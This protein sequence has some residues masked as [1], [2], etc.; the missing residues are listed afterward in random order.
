M[1][2]STKTIAVEITAVTLFA[3]VCTAAILVLTAK[4]ETRGP[5]GPVPV[6]SVSNHK[7]AQ[8]TPLEPV[9]VPVAEDIKGPAVER[10]RERKPLIDRVEPE[11]QPL[12][13]RI[14][15]WLDG[16]RDEEKIENRKQKRREWWQN[17]PRPFVVAVK[18]IA[19]VIRALP[20]ILLIA[21]V[22]VCWYYGS[23]ILSFFGIG[24]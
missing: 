18:L 2:K 14:A 19:F 1:K 9:A 8:E 12:E 6:D 23:K 20:W 21:I 13:G 7:A 15:D 4:G 10:R 16:R 22:G 24:K 17:R 3:V 11:V 5:A